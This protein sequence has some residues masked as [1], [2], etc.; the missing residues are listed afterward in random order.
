MVRADA[1]DPF[2]V[3]V[4]NPKW[5]LNRVRFHCDLSI[6][7]ACAVI[8]RHRSTGAGDDPNRVR[9]VNQRITRTWVGPTASRF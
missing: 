7:T 8:D 9:R 4:N 5:I 3:N 6:T 1:L 2:N